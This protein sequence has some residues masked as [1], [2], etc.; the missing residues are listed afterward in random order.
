[1]AA[2]AF[3]AGPDG[4]EGH[5][6]HDRSMKAALTVADALTQGVVDCLP[7][8]S[9]RWA[10]RLMAD[11]QTQAVYVIDEAN[12]WSLVSDLDIVAAAA[13]DLD[14]AG[15]SA[16]RPLLTVTGDEPL[17]VAAA[18]M[19]RTSVTHLAV[20]DEANRYPIGVLSALDVV[21]A[22]SRDVAPR[23]EEVVRDEPFAAAAVAP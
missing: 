16:V 10:A 1:M 8:T 6:G 23:R 2:M 9:M 4:A 22:L 13:G 7:R 14:T 15:D 5:C 19:A 17:T 18:L 21:R 12:R 11:H 3:R 20:L